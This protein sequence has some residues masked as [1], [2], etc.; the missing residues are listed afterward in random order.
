[1]AANS[2]PQKPMYSEL[3]K[4]LTAGGLPGLPN[5]AVQRLIA[6]EMTRSKGFGHYLGDAVKTTMPGLAVA[7]LAGLIALFVFRKPATVT[8]S[9]QDTT[10]DSFESPETDDENDTAMGRYF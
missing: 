1:M 5:A 9:S 6:P 8:E 4:P 7:F 2:L 3:Y 10:E